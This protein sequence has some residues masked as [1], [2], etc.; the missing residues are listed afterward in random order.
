MGADNGE[1]ASLHF[2]SRRRVLDGN[3][4][5]VSACSHVFMRERES[6]GYGN[7]YKETEE[8]KNNGGTG[9]V[10]YGV[11]FFSRKMNGFA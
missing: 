7:G 6:C 3:R 4:A 1:P 8:T 5:C 2:S 11:L 10:F 9:R